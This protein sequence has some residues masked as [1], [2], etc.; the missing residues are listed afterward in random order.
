M[1]HHKNETKVSLIATNR[2]YFYTIRIVC[3]NEQINFVMVIYFMNDLIYGT[4]K[5]F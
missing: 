1:Y 5:R 3:K 2:L 4:I